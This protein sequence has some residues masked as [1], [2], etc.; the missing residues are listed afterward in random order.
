MRIEI[1][2][3]PKFGVQ[4]EGVLRLGPAPPDLIARAEELI[5]IKSEE[6]DNLRPRSNGMTFGRA[7]ATAMNAS[8][9]QGGGSLAAGSLKAVD[10]HATLVHFQDHHLL[11]AAAG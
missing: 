1:A 9:N 4:T 8:M 3:Q 10:G 5:Q 2:S 7:V 11:L 6:L